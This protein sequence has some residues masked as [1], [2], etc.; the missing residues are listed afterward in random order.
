MAWGKPHAKD[1]DSVATAANQIQQLLKFGCQLSLLNAIKGGLQGR[2]SFNVLISRNTDNQIQLSSL[3]A[4]V[5]TQRDACGCFSGGVNCRRRGVPSPPHSLPETQPQTSRLT[6]VLLGILSSELLR[7]SVPAAIRA[8]EFS[9]F[10]VK[11][12]A[13]SRR[14]CNSRRRRRIARSFELKSPGP[15]D[16]VIFDDDDHDY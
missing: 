4:V 2:Q 7:W 12:T 1:D 16:A 15:D 3:Y 9:G 14:S 11:F 6:K 8:T 5:T 10:A 13:R